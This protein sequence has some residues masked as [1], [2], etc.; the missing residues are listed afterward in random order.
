LN[1]NI[2]RQKCK[3]KKTT[4]FT[5]QKKSQKKAK[6]RLKPSHFLQKKPE[7]SLASQI[8]KN[9]QFLAE[10]PSKNLIAFGF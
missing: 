1:L 8:V 7:I 6:L 2:K 5:A 9:S 4:I 10:K 3:I